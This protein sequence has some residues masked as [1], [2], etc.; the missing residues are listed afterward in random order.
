M[1]EIRGITKSYTTGN[2]VQ[3]ALDGVSIT[4]RDSEFVAV[5]GPSGSGKTTFLNI[6]G[7]FDRADAG[8]IVVGGTSTAR[9]ADADWD[10]YRNHR[11]GFIF[12]S[13]NLIPHQTVLANVE[14]ALTLAGVGREERTRR[15]RAA[16]ER[17]GLGEHVDKRPAQLSG[18]QMQRVAIARA[19]VNDPEIVLADEPT[20]ALDTE[21]GIQVMELL[22]EVARERLVIMVTH[23]PQLAEEYATRIVRIKD[24]C[25]VDDSQPVSERERRAIAASG[26]VGA[27][28]D[29]ARAP[30]QP[31]SSGGAD[32]AAE[33][34]TEGS[35]V[36]P[37]ADG[38]AAAAATARGRA[39]RRLS[40]RAGRRASMGF[41]TALSLSFNNLMTKKGRTIMTAFAGSIGIIGIAA[42]LALS[43]GVNSYIAKVE[44]DTLSSYPLTI[45]RQSYDLTSILAGDGSDGDAGA[46][47]S[48]NGAAGSGADA[49][50]DASSSTG[51]SAAA[52]PGK[53]DKIGVFTMVS[54]MFASV[55][56][57]D[58]TSFKQFLD[59]GGDGIRDH[60]SA[61][62]YDYGITPLV[63]CADTS[64]GVQELSPNAL[65][66]ALSGGASSAATAGTMMTG[67]SAFNEMID[68]PELLDEQYDVVAGRWATEPDECVLVLSKSGKASDYTLYSIGVLDP[69][70]LEQMV[71]AT[72]GGTGNV[73][74]P[75]TDADFT[76]ADA[77]GTSFKVLSPA[78][79]YRKNEET[80]GWTNMA[81][82][83]AFMQ[84][85]VASGLDLHI[86]GVVKPSPTAKSAALTQG[87]AYTS[88]LTSELMQR[89]ASSEIVQQQLAAPEVDVFTG[90][91]FDA[92]QQEAKQGVDLA[93]LFTVDEAGIRSAFSIDERKLA[94]GLDLS[95]FNLGA[96]NLSSVHLDLSGALAGINMDSLLAN[97]PAP[98]LSGILGDVGSDPILGEDELK[99]VGELS[100]SYVQGFIVWLAEHG[101]DLTPDDPEFAS[102]LLDA[103]EGY[104][105]TDE[106]GALVD[107]IVQIAGQPVAD[108][109][110]QAVRSYVTN[111][112]APYMTSVF[113]QLMQQAGDRVGAAVASQL[114]TALTG[115][116]EQ[117]AATIGPQLA[118]NLAA[119]MQTAFTVDGSA[120]ARAIHFNMDAE[121]LA[122]LMTSYANASKLTYDS[123]LTT[124]GYADAENPQ[125]VSIYPV[126]FEAKQDVLA[127]IDGYND[128]MRS[129][130]A[131]DKVIV[132]TDYMGVLMGSVTS[133]VNMISL[134]LIAFVS[135]SLVVSSIMIGIITYISVLERKKEIGI[136]RA[137]GAS[138]RN[139]ANV[140]NAETFIE[141]L[142]AGVLAIAVVVL[143][144]V[145][146]NAWALEA[147][148]VEGVMQ[149]SPLAAVVLIGISVLLTVVAG[150][151]PSR[152]A[153]RRDP[154]EALR[155]E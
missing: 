73:E 107:Q 23:N 84:Q 8:E 101:G 28:A 78:D 85:Q 143:V 93:N 119:H 112:L 115:A 139:V 70:V 47:G 31:A 50:A 95:G 141:G 39:T 123:N 142:I 117:M 36:L 106:A 41:L 5:L 44:Q 48:A 32:A 3:R 75:D 63:F 113:T 54:D 2:L 30:E 15:A 149:L 82:D 45:A 152:S 71:D 140:F 13:Y 7:G 35:T 151:I 14:L 34:D 53:D 148:Q 51:S 124:L 138:K 61:I 37:G 74:V 108:R 121:D 127:A 103:F 110:D 145:P 147:H 98:D 155:S 18:G 125:A 56:S 154:V 33:A 58:M 77:L 49:G 133:I 72:M 131:E 27:A 91:R 136:L 102:K 64:A 19:L 40:R 43:N 129:A 135:I 62:Q 150:L 97:V 86:V 122:S 92:L 90:K 24:G 81:S 76:Y 94:A 89:A 11:I 118:Q 10:A 114:E 137:M 96:L 83:E 153:A 57:N 111:Q 132:Y 55:K 26:A 21:T 38:A 29:P 66:N 99:Q 4:F 116:L 25:I 79:T 88:G 105:A 67:S 6:L 69:A 109:L 100:A 126:D 120:F 9:Y 46:S 1:I 144:S 42:I 52:Q 134:V 22:A 87:I 65:S 20:G 68:D 130:G 12:Q 146:V 128:E 59:T 60:V 17:V 104:A 80:G 16:L